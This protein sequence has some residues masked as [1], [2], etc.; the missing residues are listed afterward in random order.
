V[1]DPLPGRA[2]VVVG[3]M[4]AGKTTVARGLAE[5]WG[6][7]VRDSDA[8]L[9]AETGR[10]ARELVTQRGADGLHEL[11]AQQLLDA[12]CTV[13]VPVVAAAASAVQVERCR[14]ALHQRAVVVWLDAPVDDLVARQE[15]GQYRPVYD[16]DLRAMLVRMDAVRRPLFEQVADVT[17]H[18]APVH[19]DADPAEH[20]A[21]IAR[22]VDD[23]AAR[24]GALSR[25]E[26][27]PVA[28]VT[29]PGEAG[30]PAAAGPALP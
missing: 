29:L 6:R 20:A 18:L 16:P 3:L 30:G 2:V 27:Y 10:T 4:G 24:L 8:D 26:P 13:P 7:V 15:I 5:R 11:E 12:L 21:S 1:K 22:L 14:Q 28:A 25:A 17:V 23:V 9:L 19:P